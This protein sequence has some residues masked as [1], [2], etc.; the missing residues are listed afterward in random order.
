LLGLQGGLQRRLTNW[1]R[2]QSVPSSFTPDGASLGATLPGWT[3]FKAVS[4]PLAGGPAKLIAHQASDPSFSPDGNRVAYSRQSNRGYGIYVARA[5][6]SHPHQISSRPGMTPSWDPSGERIS[7]VVYDGE[8][9]IASEYGAGGHAYEVN[10]DSS[11]ETKLL[12]DGM[13]GIFYPVW[14]PGPGRGAGPISC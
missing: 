11:C 5:D 12:G 8:V 4:I 14:E 9:T 1:S 10:A 6:G 7:F 3:E 13:E 2:Y